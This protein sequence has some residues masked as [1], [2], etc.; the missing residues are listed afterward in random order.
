[1][2]GFPFLSTLLGDQRITR[3][4]WYCFVLF[5][6]PGSLNSEYRVTR[7]RERGAYSALPS[8]ADLTGADV[9][10]EVEPAGRR[11]FAKQA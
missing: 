10:A 9:S 5:L 8:T 7:S 4:S 6:G 3:R 2:P 1:M 11:E